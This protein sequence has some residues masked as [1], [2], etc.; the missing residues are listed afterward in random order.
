[1]AVTVCCDGDGI[2]VTKG[3]DKTIKM[4]VTKDEVALDLT[5]AAVLFILKTDE[6]DAD[7]EAKIVKKTA[8]LAGGGSEQ[9]EITNPTG[10][11][12]KVYIIPADTSSLDSGTYM[13]GVRIKTNDGKQFANTIACKFSIDVA[14]AADPI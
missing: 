1:M 7:D 4:T 14:V 2:W 8:N 9:V 11:E 3:T 12:V 6:S 5:N 13:W 10:G